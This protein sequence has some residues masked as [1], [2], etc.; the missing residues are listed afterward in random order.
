MKKNVHEATLNELDAKT[1]E[2]IESV[3][4]QVRASIDAGRLP[5]ISLPVRSLGNVKYDQA[6]GYFELGDA[7]KIRTLTVNTARTF[8]QTLR[9][10]AT[11]RTMVEHDDFATKREAYYIS[12]NWGDCQLR[13]AGRVRCRHGRHR[14]CCISTWA[15]RASSFASTRKARR[16][17]RRPSCRARHAILRPGKPVEV[18]CTNLGSGRLLD[19]ALGRAPQVRDRREASSSPSRPA[20]CSSA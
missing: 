19:P 12:K 5:N 2:V 17:G 15:C 1:I 13:R 18:D 10:M 14:G 4:Q 7:N 11:S 9:L 20:A 6:K 3:A 8:A 16:L